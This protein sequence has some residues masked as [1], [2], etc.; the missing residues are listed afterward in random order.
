VSGEHMEWMRPVY[1]ILLGNSQGRRPP[2]RPKCRCRDN[3]VFKGMG[4]GDRDLSMGL[5]VP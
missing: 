1:K 2:G 4:Y 5:R 3:I